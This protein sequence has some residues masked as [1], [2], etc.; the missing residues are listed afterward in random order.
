MNRSHRL[1]E[2]MARSLAAGLAAI[3]L[4]LSAPAIAQADLLIAPTR[5]IL[6]DRGSGQ[7]ILSNIGEKESTYRVTA[8]LRRMTPDGDIEDVDVAQATE[9]EKAALEMVR[10]A[11]RRVVLPPGQPQAIRI[12]ARPPEGLPDGE[13][14]IHMTFN[15]VPEVAPVAEAS[16]GAEPQGLSIQLTP[17]YG[18]TIPIIVRKGE[19]EASAAISNPRIERDAEGREVLRLDMARQ[20]SAS[21]FG[22]IVVSRPG[23]SDPL[24]VAR[25]IAI[26]PEIENRAVVL[27]I[28]PEQAAALKAGGMLRIEYRELQENGGALL[29]STEGAFG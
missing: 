17:I 20:G 16:A 22:E 8:E 14:R 15:G 26:Y 13:Y 25:G 7:V 5:L 11:P 12:S 6:D 3:G 23:Q 10:F 1:L 29:A 21:V 24:Y 28:T 4:G 2:R 19:L 27:P 18:I 9:L